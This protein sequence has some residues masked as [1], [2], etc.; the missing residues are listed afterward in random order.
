MIMGGGGGGIISLHIPVL[1]SDW[2][3]SEAT[4]PSRPISWQPLH[5]P[6][7]KVLALALNASNSALTTGLY[8]IA[9]AQPVRV[10]VEIN[11]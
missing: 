8:R 10:G 11:H 6:N 7:E 3:S 1:P 5:T 2:V 9:A 4:H